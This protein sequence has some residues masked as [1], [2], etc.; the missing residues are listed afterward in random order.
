MK[1]LKETQERIEATQKKIDQK[2]QSIKIDELKNR[3]EEAENAINSRYSK[4]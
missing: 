3:L 2:L 1:K 4:R